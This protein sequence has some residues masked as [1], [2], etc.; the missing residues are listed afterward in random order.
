MT[1]DQLT[2]NF[3]KSVLTDRETALALFQTHVY[4][5]VSPVIDWN[6]L[7]IAGAIHK[8]EGK[9]KGSIYQEVTYRALL[10]ENR[11]HI[12]LNVKHQREID[13]L[14]FLHVERHNIDIYQEHTMQVVKTT[15]QKDPKWPLVVT[16]VLYYG[17]KEDHTYHEDRFDYYANPELA[18]S[19]M[20]IPYIAVD[21]SAPPGEGQFSYLTP[22][23]IEKQYPYPEDIYDY[24]EDPDLARSVM[25][26]SYALVSLHKVSDECLLSHGSCGLMEVL[27]KRAT[28]ANFTSWLEGNQALL[29][30][31][32]L[33]PYLDEGVA[34]SSKVSNE[35]P[36]KIRKAFASI[37]PESTD[38]IMR[39]A[40]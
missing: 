7:A 20:T 33:V 10:K 2:I 24:Y 31:Y 13:P 6:T 30:S 15:K 29:R 37:Y 8:N 19:V 38:A 1:H 35:D 21:L 34:Y 5:E 27:L 36:S 39:A 18:R 25:S 16:I 14:M 11:G 4:S 28:S 23:G 17:I 40:K 22:S 12:Y 3:L 32:P 26:K 9:G